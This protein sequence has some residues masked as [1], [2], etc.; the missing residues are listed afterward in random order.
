MRVGNEKKK[1]MRMRGRVIFNFTA[2]CDSQ[3]DILVSLLA[4]AGNLLKI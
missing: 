1:K 4:L 3:R 2:H